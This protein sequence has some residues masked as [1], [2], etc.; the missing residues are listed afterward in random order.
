VQIP[1]VS[2][3]LYDSLL[4]YYPAVSIFAGWQFKQGWNGGILTL[5]CDT[6]TLATVQFNDDSTLVVKSGDPVPAIIATNLDHSFN[7]WRWFW[8]QLNFSFA[9]VG[10]FLEITVEVAVGEQSICS[11]VLITTISTA[12]L[13]TPPGVNKFEFGSGAG[14]IYFAELTIDTLQSIGSD[15][16]PGTPKARVTQAEVELAQ[17]P[18]SALVRITQGH[19]EVAELPD[20][21]LLRITQGVIEIAIAEGPGM[22]TYEA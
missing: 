9:D 17:V 16:N 2:G 8:F 22:R 21:A 3:L 4:V 11:G 18:D 14:G 10:G 15:P 20:S 6:H 12:A 7:F 5:K 13:S 1:G 19:G